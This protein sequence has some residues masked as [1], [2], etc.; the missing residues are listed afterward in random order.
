MTATL[1]RIVRRA[2][3]AGAGLL[4]LPVGY[5]GSVATLCFAMNAG[6]VSKAVAN[7]P[8][9]HA[10]T[11]PLAWYMADVDRPGSHTL[12]RLIDSANKAGRMVP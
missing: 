11:L 2:V 12:H 6:V 1:P 5:V 4:L 3:L 8:A 9:V 7:W 10:Y